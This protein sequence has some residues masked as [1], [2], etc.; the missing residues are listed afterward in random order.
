ML[1]NIKKKFFFSFS[2]LSELPSVNISEICFIGRSNSGKSSLINTILNKKN[3]SFSSKKAGNT[4]LINIFTLIP[5][6]SVFFV[7]DLPGYGFNKILKYNN[8]NFVKLISIYLNNR[9]N[10]I[11]AVLV[12]DS[13][14]V[15]T[16]ID[17]YFL[18]IMFHKK[19]PILILINKLDKLSKEEIKN[20]IFIIQKNLINLRTI[21]LISVI[22]VNPNNLKKIQIIIKTFL[23]NYY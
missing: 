16:D 20:N 22:K 15:M 3:L 12:I 13:R 6:N 17:F 23:L 11:C 5:K 9:F 21:N 7:V 4:N 18:E 2:E 14:R 1:L 10:L 19:L 8:L